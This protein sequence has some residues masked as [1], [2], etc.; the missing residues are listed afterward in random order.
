MRIDRQLKISLPQQ[1]TEKKSSAAI[2]E[3]TFQDS[4]LILPSTLEQKRQ[5]VQKAKRDQTK[6]TENLGKLR[7][8][9]KSFDV[10]S[11]ANGTIYYG[12]SN[13]G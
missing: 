1:L 8:D 9:L 2:G 10:D 6:A 5:A 12:L 4:M 13:D 3:I 7:A 11:P